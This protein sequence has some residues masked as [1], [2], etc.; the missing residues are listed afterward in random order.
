MKVLSQI[1]VFAG[2]VNLDGFVAVCTGSFDGRIPI[3]RR[4]KKET[5]QPILLH[6]AEEEK[7]QSAAMA[8]EMNRFDTLKDACKAC[9]ANYS[10]ANEWLRGSL[11]LEIN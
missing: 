8:F 7:V 3:D 10:K 11:S 5:R 1:D 9:E 4:Q 2:R 6:S